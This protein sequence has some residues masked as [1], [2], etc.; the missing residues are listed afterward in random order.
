MTKL[1]MLAAAAV[2]TTLVAAP[3]MAQET[4][5]YHRDHAYHHYY[6]RGPV[7]AAA[8]TAAGIAGAAIGTAGAIATAPFRYSYNDDRY[9]RRYEYGPNGYV[10]HPGTWF[11]GQDGRRHICQ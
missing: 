8:D 1:K 11:T 7:G 9:Y 5:V 3:A 4:V 10:C 2:L 6:H